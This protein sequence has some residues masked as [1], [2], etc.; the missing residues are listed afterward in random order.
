[1]KRQSLRPLLAALLIASSCGPAWA[2][3]SQAGRYFEDALKRFEAKDLD[4]ATIQLKNALQ[5]DRNHLPAQLLMGKVALANSD[6]QRAEIALGEALRLGANRNEVVVPL[7]QAMLQLGR[8]QQ[9][10][11]DARTQPTGLSDLNQGRLLLVRAAA[12]TDLGE[13]AMAVSNIE[14]ARALLGPTAEGWLAEAHLRMRQRQYEQAERAVERAMALGAGNLEALQQKA[15]LAHVQG[16]FDAALALYDQMLKLSP[17]HLEARVAR[18]GLLLD[19]QRHEGMQAEVESLLKSHPRDPRVAYFRALMADQRGDRVESLAA[20]RSVTEL[21]DPVPFDVIRFR[22]QILMLNGL[23]H[24]ALGEFS[25]AKPYLEGLQRQNPRSPTVKLQAQILFEEGQVE[26]GIV[27]LEQYLRLQPNDAQALALLAS[28]HTAQG[29]HAKAIALMEEALRGRENDEL[30]GVLGL[31]LLRT[32]QTQQ[33]QSV[34]EGT[35]KRSPRQVQAG[36]SLAM[37]YLRTQQFAQAEKLVQSLLGPRS[38]RPT[39]LHL[40][41]MARAGKGDTKGAAQAFAEALK[42]DPS[43]APAQISLARLD[44]QQGQVQAAVQRLRSLIDRD[45]KHID[46]MLELAGVHL[47]AGN[48]G[49]AE[50]WLERAVS[51]APQKE[52]RP[53]VALVELRLQRGQREEALAAAN[54]LMGKAPEELPAL[55]VLAKVHMS[56]QEASSARAVLVRAARRA[57]FDA[58]ALAEIGG[59]QLQIGD[60]EGARYS[61]EKA[62]QSQAGHLQAQGLLASALLRLGQLAEAQRLADKVLAAAPAIATSHLLQA[63]LAVAARHPERALGHL[64]KAHEVQPSTAT[65]IRLLEQLSA[66]D[67]AAATRFAEDWLR[68]R[69]TDS[70]MLRS[71]ASHLARR[72]QFE[73]AR[74]S[75]ENLLKL[76][77]RDVAAHNDLANVL[78]RLGRLEAAAQSAE[79]ARRLAPQSVEVIDTQAWIHFHRNEYDQALTLLREARLRAPDNSEIRY[80]LAA[81]L[82]KRGQRS[83]ARAELDAALQMPASLE[84]RQ[85]AQTLR[86][87]LN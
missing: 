44:A 5:Q 78:L 49:E 22:P 4:G 76:Q 28:G 9:M 35:V 54:A 32:G 81:V 10:L 6:P 62:L 26:N 2:Q 29:R 40:L 51:A 70:H 19:L 48:A 83:E 1:M 56:R 82:A 66:Q 73:P 24:F 63:D 60:A 42:L 30:R 16:Q 55:V 87:A 67:G 11:E 71:L 79:R 86:A 38:L 46:A 68:R 69:P 18:A 47:R 39:H 34:L 20:L 57:G 52:W 80:H 8:H 43:L 37:L 72:Q 59:M 23:A 41:G 33:A 53:D 64:R 50:R 7:A 75:Y 61:L 85:E 3:V 45:N 65:A 14:K 27:M 84:S 58:G 36:I 12:H 17:S 15:S 74:A 21:V 77:P 13:D 31:S 25:K